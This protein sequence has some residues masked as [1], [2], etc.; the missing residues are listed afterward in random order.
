MAHS[1]P[2][3]SYLFQIEF[4]LLTSGPTYMM[5]GIYYLLP[6]L[7]ALYDQAALKIR[8]AM[9]QVLLIF[10][11]FTSIVLQSVGAGFVKGYVSAHVTSSEIGTRLVIAG[12][13]VQLFF[14]LV[15]AALSLDFYLR[16]Q[17]LKAGANHARVNS[18]YVDSAN[19]AKMGQLAIAVTIGF[20][21]I[22]I[23]S[24]TR[25]VGMIQGMTGH[26]MTHEAFQL[27]L[28]ALPVLIG[29]VALTIVHP[30]HVLG[31]EK[32]SIWSSKRPISDEEYALRATSQL[33]N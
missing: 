30:G 8:P 21:A 23:R 19:H 17:N 15:Y 27:G 29:A 33:S 6:Q 12:F 2:T 4:V 26:I 7:A 18:M 13:A 5:S 25:L 3:N 14:M 28:E 11:S 9:Y 24:V 31:K 20:F 10:F 16:I 22:L 32:L 1:D